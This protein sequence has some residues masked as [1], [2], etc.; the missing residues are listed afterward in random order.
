M[1]ALDRPFALKK[2]SAGG[3]HLT[4]MRSNNPQFGDAPVQGRA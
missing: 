4:A 1:A 3:L 2:R